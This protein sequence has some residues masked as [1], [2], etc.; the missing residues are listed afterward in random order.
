MTWKELTFVAFL[1]G[2]ISL[3][4]A[5]AAMLMPDIV[6]GGTTLVTTTENVAMESKTMLVAMAKRM[7]EGEWY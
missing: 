5:N 4:S 7:N 2:S 1:V 3:G 6:I